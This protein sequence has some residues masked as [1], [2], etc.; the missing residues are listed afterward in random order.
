M[1]RTSNTVSPKAGTTAAAE[2]VLA[3]PELQPLQNGRL[4]LTLA[5][6][7][8]YAILARLA[9]QDLDFARAQQH[10][11]R[12]LAQS[13]KNE[14]LLELRAA[15]YLLADDTRGFE[16]ALIDMHWLGLDSA[17]VYRSIAEYAEKQHRY[18][19]AIHLLRRAVT[20]DPEAAEGRAQLGIQL[21]RNGSEAE[22]RR[23]L[24]QALE[25][26]P[27]N[28]RARNTLTLFERE[29]DQHYCTVQHGRFSLRLPNR[30]RETLHAVV[31][32]WLERAQK[33]FDARWGRLLQPIRIEL[34]A[35][36]ESF[37]VRTSGVPTTLIEG[38]CFGT[39]IVA[40]LPND[41]PTNL[42]MTLWHEMS[43]VYHYQLSKQRVPRWF[44]EGLA[45]VETAHERES[46]SHE[47]ELT[48]Y[49]ALREDRLPLVS[50]LN[51]A[52][53][54]AESTNDLALAYVA[55]ADLVGYLERSYGFVRLRKMLDAWSRHHSTD[56][57][58]RDVLGIEHQR[59]DADYRRALHERLAYLGRQYIPSTK[60]ESLEQALSKGSPTDVDT[61][62]LGSMIALANQQAET[63][64]ALLARMID[65]GYDGYFV[66]LQLALVARFRSNVEDERRQLRKA[67]AFLPTAAEP[68]FRLAAIANAA[69]DTT[70]ELEAMEPL[71]R[72]EE[73]N[74]LV[75]LRL[76]ELY[77]QTGDPKAARSA[78]V[79]LIHVD[80]LSVDVHRSIARV[81][82]IQH[83]TALLMQ[84]LRHLRSLL[85]K[86]SEREQVEDWMN[87]AAAGRR[88][89]FPTQ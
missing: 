73:A 36:Q 65:Q 14:E 7:E 70:A 40:R 47:R 64:A 28:L 67:H 33:R 89:E 25:R 62:W 63:A 86:G 76:V 88:I 15:A 39:T 41:E 21:L 85:P 78:A 56:A 53:A 84:A 82:Q 74:L 22:G 69:R 75:Q 51:R 27:F 61:L 18:D 23:E 19:L 31:L 79:D 77:L 5:D 66:R 68:L 49:R 57:V 71:A 29:L 46:W 44:T 43:H 42:G 30:H 35:D 4:E 58:I 20:L 1:A 83:D 8:G 6:E 37:G 72:L 13:P 26:D 45:Q 50:Q 32:P 48:L 2:A 9:L 11:R 55:S 54:R 24:R 87:Q 59:L 80:P 17:K 12:G 52:F 3:D 81:A 60:P 38:V 10:T 16:A 34:Y